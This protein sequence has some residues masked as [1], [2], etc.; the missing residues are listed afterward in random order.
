MSGWSVFVVVG[1]FRVLC[2]KANMAGWAY[3]G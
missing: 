1:L 3:D 2:G